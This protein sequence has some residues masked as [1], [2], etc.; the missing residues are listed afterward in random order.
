MRWRTIIA[1]AWIAAGLLAVASMLAHADLV[2]RDSGQW[3]YHED[4]SVAGNYLATTPDYGVQLWNVSAAPTLLDD[5]YL[6]GDVAASVS[7][8]GTLIAA[9]DEAGSLYL[10]NATTP[11]A[12]ALYAEITSIGASGDVILR[13]E[14]GTVWA[15]Y[16]GGTTFRTRDVTTPASSTAHDTEALTGNIV[17]IALADSIAVV[18]TSSRVYTINVTNHD[19]LVIRDTETPADVPRSCDAIGSLAAVS[20]GATGVALYD[21]STP[22][23]VSLVTTF[24]P[25]AG[26]YTNFAARGVALSSTGDS[27]LV[28]GNDV[29]LTVWDVSTPSSPALLAYDP[30]LDSGGSIAA[31]A[32]K[33]AAWAANKGYGCLWGHYRAG[34]YIADVTSADAD[35]L[36]RAEGFDYVRNVAA[37]GDLVY[38]CT[39]GGGLVAHDADDLRSRRGQHWAESVWGAAVD[40]ST[41]YACSYDDGFISVDFSDPDA[42]AQLDILDTLAPRGVVLAGTVAYVAD[43]DVGL[44][45][46]DISTPAALVQ[47][48]ASDPGGHTYNVDVIPHLGIAATA[49]ETDGLNVWD[50]STPSDLT[51]LGNVTLGGNVMDVALSP[52]AE[53]A[54]AVVTGVGVRC[55]SLANPASPSAGAA[56]GST[57]VTGVCRLGGLLC[58]SAGADGVYVYGLK[59][60][61]APVLLESFNTGSDALG[62][63]A[64]IVGGRYTVYVADDGALLALTLDV[65]AGAF[66][67]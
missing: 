21:I 30:R 52:A 55:V 53:V 2:Y 61:L 13:S 58:V 40:G 7:M 49:D 3:T 36:G 1:C 9:T 11:T 59:D 15:Y 62:L 32:Y 64:A 33:G 43:Y 10:L 18:A 47:L 38:G 16:G 14:S 37:G 41:V 28:I 63:T 42:P 27:L 6:G 65:D 67:E 23:A 54:Y 26:T 4:C 50:V 51:L 57:H 66:C 8:L 35:S 34:V 22:S 46:V 19:A 45:S 31:T 44:V 39:G 48:D 24:T 56:L 25:D 29:G 17:Q 20:L 5:Y 12:L 60:P